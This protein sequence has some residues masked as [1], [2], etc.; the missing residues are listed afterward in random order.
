[1]QSEVIYRALAGLARDLGYVTDS[2]ETLLAHAADIMADDPRNAG[3]DA[4]EGE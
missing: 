3:D 4:G 1:V 2:V